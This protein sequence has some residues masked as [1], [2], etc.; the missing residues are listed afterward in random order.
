MQS[1]ISEFLNSTI[2]FLKYVGKLNGP[3]VIG[4]NK[5]SAQFTDIQFGPTKEE[6]KVHEM[7]K[8]VEFVEDEDESNGMSNGEMASARSKMRESLNSNASTFKN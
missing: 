4:V 5:Y 1:I 7:E 2:N 6:R 8:S 3:F